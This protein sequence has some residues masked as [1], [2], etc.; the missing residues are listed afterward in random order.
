MGHELIINKILKYP[1]PAKDKFRVKLAF[2]SKIQ[3][4]ISRPCQAGRP[5]QHLVSLA[6]PTNLT[7][8]R[9]HRRQINYIFFYFNVTKNHFSR[10]F[11]SCLS[12]QIYCDVELR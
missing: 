4:P 6:V 12:K 10:G 2:Q 1:N 7:L 3:L 5:A 8:S 11:L 9:N